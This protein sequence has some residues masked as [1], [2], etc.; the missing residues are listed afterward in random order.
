MVKV[1]VVLVC[2][3]AAGAAVIG[4]SVAVDHSAAGVTP[5]STTPQHVT[6]QVVSEK[7]AMVGSNL[8]LHPGRVVLTIVNRA[9]HSHLFT[10]PALGI[11]HVVLPGAASA[12]SR[13]T[14]KFT[15]PPGVFHW[16]CSLPCDKS[17]SGDIYAV[18]HPPRL[19]GA[20]WASA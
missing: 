13:T 17:M 8:V 1:L 19:H 5:V 9:H 10:V 2:A 11:E 15:V 18:K 16:F 12:P 3:V 7:D 4:A 20:L 14:I 6:L